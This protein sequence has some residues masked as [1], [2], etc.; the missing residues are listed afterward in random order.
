VKGG[1]EGRR[2]EGIEKEDVQMAYFL[3]GGRARCPLVKV[4]A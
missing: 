3:A 1:G 4:E 2:G